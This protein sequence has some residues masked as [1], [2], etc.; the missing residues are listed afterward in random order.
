MLQPP[1]ELSPDMSPRAAFFSFK[2]RI[3][4]SRYW[5]YSVLLNIAAAVLIYM[6]S[7]FFFQIADSVR[8][9]AAIRDHRP[10]L[11][12]VV[13]LLLYALATW[14]GLSL[15]VK[16]LHDRGRTGWLSLLNL[17]PIVGPLL[18]AID[19]YLLSGK[20]GPNRYGS[21][22]K[23][24]PRSTAMEIVVVLIGVGIFVG[25]LVAGRTFVMEPFNIPSGSGEPTIAS[26]DYV[27]VSRYAYRLQQPEHG[28]VAV[29][30]NPHTGEDYIKRI[31]GLPGDTVQLSH[32]IVS[33]NGR[34]AQRTRIADYHERTWLE[35]YRRYEDNVRYRYTETLPD[36]QPHEILGGYVTL[37]E[38]SLPQDNT[39]TFKVPPDRFFAIGDNRD[40]SN[41]SRLELGYVPLA[42]LVGRAE[43]FYFSRA[44]GIPFW[45]MMVNFFVGT[46]WER[47]LRVVV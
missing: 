19:T 36:G 12:I 11:F 2:G 41:D 42:N 17:I 29:F 23:S 7:V 46:R 1:P 30:I 39:G 14:V 21:A 13:A 3:S 22:P 40:N 20:P 24:C 43:L 18:L 32:G 28:E 16:R 25:M 31:V 5:E 15:Q 45:K 9:S 10:T 37:P 33:I 47:M 34:A 4:R 26:G 35:M 44:P 8:D 6:I 38:D 27:A